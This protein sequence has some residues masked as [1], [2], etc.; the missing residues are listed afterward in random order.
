ME[1]FIFLKVQLMLL[2]LRIYIILINF[3]LLRIERYLIIKIITYGK[4][5]IK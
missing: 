3:K 4:Q 2:D 1:I 5:S